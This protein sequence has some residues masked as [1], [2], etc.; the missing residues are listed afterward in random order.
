MSDGLTVTTKPRIRLMPG[1]FDADSGGL[2]VAAR[3]NSWRRGSAT[4]DR[5]PLT[6]TEVRPMHS[7]SHSAIAAVVALLR[8]HRKTQREDRMR[9]ANVW[10]ETGHVFSTEEGRPI[11]PRNLLRRL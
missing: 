11:E 9:A 6:G 1:L 8:A 4:P 3:A 10:Q 2:G 5:S 7:A